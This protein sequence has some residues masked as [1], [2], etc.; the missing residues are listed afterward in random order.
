MAS[1]WKKDEAGLIVVALGMFVYC[2]W[3]LYRVYVG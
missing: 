1:N 2:L 3:V